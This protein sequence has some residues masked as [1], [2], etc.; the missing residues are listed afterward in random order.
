MFSSKIKRHALLAAGALIALASPA[1][2]KNWGDWG[3]PVSVETLPGSGANVNTIYNDGCPVQS[4]D[5]LDLYIASNRPGGHGGQDIWVAHRNSTNEGWGNPINLDAVNSSAD[6]FCPLPAHGNRLFFVS[7]RDEPN[8]D[9]YVTR[10]NKNHGW[11]TPVSL[12]PN[13][14][15]PFQEWSPSLFEDEQGRDVL[16]FSSTRSNNQQD[17]YVSVDLGPAVPV[18]ELNTTGFDDARPNVSKDGLEIV[19]DS[20]RTGTLGGPDLWTASREST[21]DPWGD[22]THL[23]A[24][25]NSPAAETRATFSW[26]GSTIVFGS[27]RPGVEIAP[28]FPV[29]ADIF[30]ITREKVTG[31]TK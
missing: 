12:G 26:D 7:R 23:P 9:I 1:I 20:T 19:F 17:I 5:G 15:S 18:S 11:D 8:G 14:N 27:N 4:P 31:K 13:V 21:N 10:L 22:L 25:I 2:A 29:A 24:P 6:D 30:M 16:Y 3:A 28:G